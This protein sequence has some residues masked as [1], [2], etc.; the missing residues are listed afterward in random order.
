[1]PAEVPPKAGRQPEGHTRSDGPALR[2]DVTL[3]R[4]AQGFTREVAFD[5]P[6]GVTVLFGPSGVGKSTTLAAIA[7]LVT[8]ARGRIAL[9]DATWFDAAAGVD[10]PPHRRRVAYVFQSL[11]LFPHMTAVANVAYGIDP[12]LPVAERRARA[13]A[14]L[15]RLR[16]PHLGDRKPPT[17]SG[18]EAQRVALARALATDPRVVLLDEPFTALDADL[19][20][21]LV[22][23]VRTFLRDLSVPVVFVTHDRREAEVMG[24]RLVTLEPTASAASHR[25]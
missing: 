23:E 12:S 19:R 21:R 8:P 1:M 10:V 15:E 13:A 17:F 5:A 22:D 20:A 16:V 14:W 9:G 24:D 3:A 4:P 11:A 6:P 7:G 18:G 2:V 25:E